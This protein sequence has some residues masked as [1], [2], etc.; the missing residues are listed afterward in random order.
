MLA[1]F[2]PFIF[3]FGE[4]LCSLEFDHF[5]AQA[6][7]DR[8]PSIFVCCLDL[9]LTHE[10]A[11]SLAAKMARLF[12]DPILSRVSL[13]AVDSGAELI[14]ACVWPGAAPLPGPL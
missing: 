13:A 4:L 3:D 1:S 11:A 12:C 14:D 10:C 2:L 7:L 9:C 5:L 6:R 8:Q